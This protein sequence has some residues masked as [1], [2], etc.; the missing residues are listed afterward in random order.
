MT[1]SVDSRDFRDFREPGAD[2]AVANV[3]EGVHSGAIINL[4]FGHRYTLDA[5]PIILD[6]LARSDSTRSPSPSFAADQLGPSVTLTCRRR[7][8]QMRFS[9]LQADFRRQGR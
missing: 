2:T 5:L 9:I 3:I 7:D 6:H 4:H 8:S 1:A